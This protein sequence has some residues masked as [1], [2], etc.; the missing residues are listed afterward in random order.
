[1]KN[2]YNPHQVIR[3][4]PIDPDQNCKVLTRLET[5]PSCHCHWAIN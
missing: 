4:S 1:M 2:T 3:G 5:A